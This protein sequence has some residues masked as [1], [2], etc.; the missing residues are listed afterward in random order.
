MGTRF[1]AA[2][3]FILCPL[4]A[5]EYRGTFS[6]TIKDPQGAPVAAAKVTATETQTGAKTEV[7]SESTGAYTL[8]FLAPGT[9]QIKVE[10]PGFKQFVRTGLTLSASEHPVIDITMQVGE[11][12]QSV[13]VAAE[14]PLLIASNASVGQTV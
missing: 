9:Y 1:L 13:T 12:S 10:A 5:Q 4:F 2:A 14:A 8:S 11:V 3:I 7:N 6:G